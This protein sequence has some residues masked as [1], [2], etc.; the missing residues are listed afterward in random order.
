[1]KREAK[2]YTVTIFGESYSIVSDESET[3]LLESVRLVDELMR[4]LSGTFKSKETPR[5]AVLTAVQLAHRLLT[6]Q[7]TITASCQEMTDRIDQLL[8]CQQ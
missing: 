8:T 6:H 5:M 1:M 7:A 3:V 2:K 4:E